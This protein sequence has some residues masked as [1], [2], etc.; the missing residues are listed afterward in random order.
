M[1]ALYP[2]GHRLSGTE[3]ARSLNRQATTIAQGHYSLHRFGEP[4]GC[5]RH[6]ER[7]DDVGSKLM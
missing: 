6:R 5:A 2:Q 7:A 3:F 4:C 1:E